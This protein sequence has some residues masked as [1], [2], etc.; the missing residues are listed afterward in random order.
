MALATTSL[1]PAVVE[2]QGPKPRP[3]RFRRWFRV[4]AAL[5]IALWVA[6]IGISLL[7]RHSRINRFLTV[8][9]ASAFGRPVQVDRYDLSLLSGIRLK[10]ESVTVGEDPRFG[11]EYFLR[12]EELTAS[13]RWQALLRGHI[14]FGTL[15]F[16]RPSLNLVLA[17]DGRWNLEDWL[18]RPPGS[19]ASSAV[20]SAPTPPS[21]HPTVPGTAASAV[22]RLMRIEVESGRIDFKRGPDKLPF[23][24][25][26]VNG[27]V[28]QDGP[29]R[30]SLDLESRPMRA[31]VV[32]QEAGTI[33]VRGHVG[34]TS[35][36]LRPVDLELNWADASLSDI[37]R[38]ARDQDYGIR[39]RLSL[40][41]QAHSDGP[42]WNFTAATQ[43]RRL[44]RWDLPLQPGDPAF[45]LNFSAQWWPSDSRM[46][47][48]HALLEA[49]RSTARASGS[50]SWA[51]AA[52]GGD[53]RA[54]PNNFDMQVLSSAIDLDDV[55]AW[56]RAFHSGVGNELSLRGTAGVDLALTSWPPRIEQAT[57]VT[58]DVLLEGGSLREPVRVSG[59]SV[60][61]D[62]AN[63]VL[64]P[65]NIT[66]AGQVASIRLEASGRHTADWQWNAKT[67]GQTERLQN[68]FA[69]AAATG[70]ALPGG[71]AMEGPAKFDLRWQD[72]RN[73]FRELPLGTI[74]VAGISIRAPFLNQP[75]GQVKAHVDLRPAETRLNLAS[76]QAFGAHWSGALRRA[77][78]SPAW[79]G[80][81]SAD[82]LS[83]ANFDRW[84][85]PRW[86]ESLI[87]RV[88]PILQPAQQPVSLPAGMFLH[89][90]LAADEVNIEPATLH[91][92]RATLNVDLDARRL[93]LQ[94]AQ[95]DFYSGTVQ[96]S[97]IA[98][99]LPQPKYQIN[100]K[101]DH[102]DLRELVAI[103]ANL[104]QQFA[105]T[106]SGDLS[107]TANGTGREALV[108]SLEGHGS[109]E[110]RDAQIN[111]FDFAQST[112]VAAEPPEAIPFRLVSGAFS[113]DS[114]KIRFANLHLIGAEDSWEATG[115]VDF[116]HKLDFRLRSFSP[117]PSEKSISALRVP[118]ADLKNSLRFSGSLESPQVARITEPRPR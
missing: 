107:L 88:L 30:W 95:A 31:A 118:P 22:P 114:G 92:L 70:W 80:S 104:Q 11:N 67:A 58:E 39:G 38:L 117:Q 112:P 3:S 51:R 100:A 48:L 41:L 37:L 1:P 69:A 65:V 90:Q 54:A 50:F 56:Y 57:V 13:L 113:L 87:E 28:E 36:R 68:L 9:L 105:G 76:A 85:N 93:E 81:L 23:A 66:L 63:A 108:S 84:L 33:R 52:A 71:W 79:E 14:E 15:S 89:A 5:A 110:V 19:F 25:V 43:F 102:V 21:A 44:H 35:S 99:L 96:A 106:T 55:L 77:P 12:A 6:S 10:A 17:P 98:N 45:N 29:G 27:V 101:L 64:A 115:T 2:A 42:D 60:H 82:H 34:G 73:P 46:E 7:L 47:L 4:I 74:D 32:V 75:I 86:R 72:A 62:R 83:V 61:V 26:G 59:V 49:P 24:L 111:G 97:F 53:L 16:T 20:P 18:P 109:I 91:H 8:R 94:D 40:L 78:N 116:S 103:T